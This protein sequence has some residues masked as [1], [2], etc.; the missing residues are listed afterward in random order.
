MMVSAFYCHKICNTNKVLKQILLFLI[1]FCISVQ[2]KVDNE[3]AVRPL[4]TVGLLSIF[5]INLY[6]FHNIELLTRR[7]KELYLNF[8]VFTLYLLI[9]YMFM[10]SFLSGER[11]IKDALYLFYWM[12]LIPSALLNFLNMQS[13]QLG[14]KYLAQTIVWFAFFS[15][16]VAILVFFKYVKL[17]FGDYILVQNYWT[18]FRIHGAMGQPTALGGLLGGGLIFLTY[19]QMFS[20]GKILLLVQLTLLVAIVMS[21][22]RSAFVA[23]IISYGLFYLFIKGA[24]RKKILLFGLVLLVFAASISSFVYYDSVHMVGNLNRVALDVNNPQSR[25]FVW[26]TVIQLFL[27][28]E[29]L[30][31]IFFGSGAGELAARYRAAFNSI[32]HILFDYGVFGMLLFLFT[33]FFSLYIGIVN[34]FKTKNRL[35]QLGLMMLIYSFVFNL[36]ISSFVS[37]FFSFHVFFYILGI[38]IVNIPVKKLNFYTCFVENK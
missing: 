3:E 18:A 10:V 29:N 21:G 28:K 16:I 20:K 37:P 19:L 12:L 23:L 4:Y 5:F 24:I 31:S 27:E 9:A 14:M 1:L 7:V 6:L 35:Y 22:S 33:F 13:Y 32:L 11:Q 36:F 17:S 26:S 8:G 34:Y 25:F 15:S 30:I 2:Y 38:F